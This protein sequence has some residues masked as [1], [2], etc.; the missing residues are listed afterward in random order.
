MCIRRWSAEG[1][2]GLSLSYMWCESSR[3]CHLYKSKEV[4]AI[5][6]SIETKMLFFVK[7]EFQRS[8]TQH[9]PVE[10]DR[11]KGSRQHCV[12]CYAGGRN[13]HQHT[14]AMQHQPRLEEQHSAFIHYLQ[15]TNNDRH[16]PRLNE[17]RIPAQ[18]QAPNVVRHANK[19]LL[20][21]TVYLYLDDLLPDM[22][23]KNCYRTSNKKTHLLGERNQED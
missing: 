23:E 15:P 17:H 1:H 4:I 13:K 11:K 16:L 6:R 12:C 14:F 18:Q 7:Q 8:L 2:R 9:E 5:P 19:T 10:G 22:N 20:I 3:L 21:Q